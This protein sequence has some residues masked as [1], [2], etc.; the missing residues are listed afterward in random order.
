MSPPQLSVALSAAGLRAVTPD[1]GDIHDAAFHTGMYDRTSL[2]D[3]PEPQRGAPSTWRV[4][5]TPDATP[6]VLLIV[7]ADDADALKVAADAEDAQAQRAGATIIYAETGHLLPGATEHF[8]FRDGV[9]QPAVRGRLSDLD[10]HFLSRRYIHPDEPLALTDSRPGHPLIWPGQFVFGYL[11]QDGTDPLRGLDRPLPGPDW[12]RDG[13]F[14]VFRRFQQD[15]AAFRAGLTELQGQIRAQIGLALSEAQIGALLVGRWPRGTALTRNSDADEPAPM[16]HRLSVNYF[17]FGQR[18]WP[19]R[20]AN[21]RWV[22]QEELRP[23]PGQ[24]E[25]F[26]TVQGSPADELAARCPHFAH[27][28]NVNP[29]DLTTDQGDVADTLTRQVLRRG[30]TYG[31]PYPDDPEQQADDD[32]NRGLLFLAYQT[33]IVDQFETLNTRWMNRTGAPEGR[34]GHDLLLGQAHG[35][36]GGR[37]G[38]LT[39]GRHDAELRPSASWVVP[40]GGGYFFAPSVSALRALARGGQPA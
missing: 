34:S 8:G 10:R 22:E 6:H 18:T 35:D 21:D 5:G 25:S 29:R 11:A 36:P 3:P 19:V 32:G 16:D 13:S 40:A 20:V 28:R 2:G 4:G 38:V 15:V 30:I 17:S 39:V 14:L 31:D 12:T 9:S 37:R 1:A 26:S 23:K 24:P 33:S 27:I 7:A